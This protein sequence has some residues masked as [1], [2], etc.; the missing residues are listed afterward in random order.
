[1]R[2]PMKKLTAFLV[3]ASMS[4]AGFAQT[5]SGTGS[6]VTSSTPGTVTIASKG[7]DVRYV[8]HDLF[9]QSKKNYVLDPGVRFVLF[10]SLRDVDFD[11][12]LQTICKNASLSFE[13][14]NGIYY[15]GKAKSTAPAKDSASAPKIVTPKSETKPASQAEVKPTTTPKT[16]KTQE[17][18][19]SSVKVSTTSKSAIPVKSVL[20]NLVTIRVSKTDIKTVFAQIAK[21]SHS[22]ITL[23]KAIPAYR[24]DVN[25]RQTSLKYALDTICKAAALKYTVLGDRVTITQK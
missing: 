23:D 9:D 14:Q 15:V 7:N 4:L 21:Q 2:T 11:E 12:A 18:P 13:I 20:V 22:S 25:L 17:S 24:L 19:A 16:P 6:A 3:L 8:L 10:L 5:N 1:M